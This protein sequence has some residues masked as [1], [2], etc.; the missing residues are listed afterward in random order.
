MGRQFRGLSLR[1]MN[2]TLLE[3]PATL[4]E[5]AAHHQAQL[6]E[7]GWTVF[8]HIMSPAQLAAGQA[9]IDRIIASQAGVR[10]SNQHY[11]APNLV[12]RDPIFRE[13]AC[14]PLILATVEG[15]IGA[16][17]ILSSCNLGA[18][19][20]GGDAQGLHRDTGIWGSS[21]P[22]MD[23]PIGIQTAWCFDDFTIENGATHLVPGSH[24]RRD[25]RPDEPSIQAVAPA[26]SIIAFDCQAFHA[27]G[28]NR[29]ERIRR[30][31][32]TLYIRSWIKPQTDHKRSIA[33]EDIASA[34]PTMLRLLGFQRQSPTEGPDGKPHFVMAPGASNFYGQP[35]G[36][37]AATY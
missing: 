13:I 19:R 34:S 30:A 17:C 37:S 2:T 20:P 8:R 28:A 25:A 26:G 16:D 4:A 7:Q 22:F 11:H 31:A 9:A 5:Q 29:T 23:F 14:L 10:A 24:A 33:A 18:R 15:L 21:M 3:A 6:R 1:G 35:L 27:G 36:E 32:L 12:G